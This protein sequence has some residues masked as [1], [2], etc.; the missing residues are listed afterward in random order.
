MKFT[1]HENFSFY[2]ERKT[3]PEKTP[4]DFW[5][6]VRTNIKLQHQALPIKPAPRNGKLPLS[7]AQ[8]RLWFLDQLQPDS[9]VHNKL[10]A[11]RFKGLLNLA[12]L[13]QSLNEIVQRHEILRTTFPAVKGQPIQVISSDITLKLTVIDLRELPSDQREAQ[14][15]RLALEEAEQPFNLERE[16]LWRVQLLHLTEGEHLFLQTVHHIIFDGWSYG[17]FMRE[18]AVLY[19]AFS[20]GKT[21]ML[22]ELPIQYADFA[23]YQRQ[24]LQGEVLVSQFDYWQQQLD[25][26]LLPLELPVDRPRPILP[27]YRGA[28][29]SL[30][31]SENLTNALKAL[32]HQEGVSLFVTLLAAFKT[33]LFRYTGQED[34]I[35]CSPVAGRNRVEIKKLIGYFNNLLVMRTDLG[36]NPSFRELMSRVSRTTLGAYQHQ[37][38]P[39]QKLTEL[40]NLVRTPLTRGMFVLQNT[41][42]QPLTLADISVTPLDLDWGTTN[43]DLSLSMKETEEQLIGVLSYKTDLFAG[44]T[45]TQMIEDFQ[46]LLVDLAANPD[47]CL[48][49][50]QRFD[51]NGNPAS[52]LPIQVSQSSPSPETSFVPPRTPT[53]E[54]LVT[55]WSDI[56]GVKVGICDSFFE[57]GGHSLLATQLISRI[58]DTFAVEWP[59]HCLFESPTIEALSKYLEA[60]RCQN[61]LQPPPPLQPVSRSQQ[62]LLSFAQQRLWFLDQLETQSTTYN[63]LTALRLIG[64]LQ[65]AVLERSIAEI[66]R[67]H[68]ALRTTFPMVN[69]TPVQVIA[70]ALTMT[71][72]VR[73]WQHLPEVK[74]SIEV[75]QLA[76]EESQQPFDLT[77]GSLMRVTLLRLGK[78]SHVLLLTVHHIVTDGWSMEIFVQELSTLYQAFSTE[79]RSP[80]PEL[81]IQY[82]DF[83]HWQRQWLQG[84]VL[85]SQLAY[86]KQ[87]LAGA[88][89][90]LQLP[91]DRPRPLVQTFRGRTEHFQLNSNLTK[92]LKLLSQR[93][94]ATLFMT[95]L[96]A[97]ATLLSYYSG[98]EDIIVGSGIANRNR[99]EIEPLIGFFVNILVL[100]INLQ[101]N[102]TF[103]ELLAQ[104]RQVALDAYAHQ[105]LPFEKLV[106]ELRPERKLNHSPLFQVAFFL[107]NMPRE[108][109]ELPDLS[110]IPWELEN[111]TAK[112][113][114]TLSMLELE[115][116]LRGSWEYNSDLFD[117]ATIAR[118]TEHFQ[119]LLAA[120]VVN[121]EQNLSALPLLTET[122]HNQLLVEW[123]DTQTEYPQDKCIHQLFEAQVERT[124]EAV[125]VVFEDQ[126]LKYGELNCRA[127]QLA[128]H[129]Q[130]WGVGP[131]VLVGICI[132]RSLE[133]I[134]GLL[135]ILKAGGAYLP[136]EPA[137]PKERLA[138][139]ISDAQVSLLLTTEALGAGLPE[140]EASVV[141]LDT[142][143]ELI[144][145][146]SERNLTS[147]VKSD[148]LAYVIYTSASTGR[149]KGVQIHHYSLVNFLNSMRLSPGLTAQDILLAITTISFDIAVLE[150]YLPLIVGAKVVLATRED[151]SEGSKLLSMLV[152]SGATVMQGTP[153]TWGLLLAAGWSGSDRL[154]VLCG[155][156][157]LT[158]ELANQ[159]LAKSTSVWNLYGP[160]ETSIWSTA[161]QVKSQDGSVCIG[162]PIANTQIYLLNSH[163]KPVPIGVPGELHIGGAG[164]AR[165]Y[166]NRPELTKE[167]FIPNPFSK[168]PSARLYKTGDLARYLPN[169]NIEFLDRLDHQVKIRGFR[170]ELG[171]V[172]S[173]LAQHPA[174]QQTVVIVREYL[175]DDKR[176]V[177]YV[178]PNETTLTHNQLRCFLK[179]KLPHHLVP[180]TFVLLNTLPLNPNGKV[181]RHTLPAPERIGQELAENFVA[182][183]DELEL[184]LAQIW[185]QVLGTYPVGVRNDFF[186][187][188]GHSLLAVN[189][190]VQ[191]EHKLGVDL[192][193][194]TLFQAPTIEQLA[195]LLRQ[196]GWSSSWSSL[197]GI[198]PSGLR[199]PFFFHGGAAD[200]IHW[201]KLG[202]YL[203]PDQPFYALQRPD[204]NRKQAPQLPV[205]EL[206]VQ[207]IQEIRTVQPKGPYL[208]GGQ[209]F[210]GTVVFE[211]AQ[212]FHRQGEKVDLLVL[213]DA[214]APQLVAPQLGSNPLSFI[215]QTLIHN[216]NFWLHYHLAQL[217]RHELKGKLTYFP[218]QLLKWLKFQLKQMIIDYQPFQDKL[219]RNNDTEDFLPH[220]L[221]YS[222]AEKRSR[223]AFRSY[224]PQAYP[225]RIILFRA[226]KQ[227]AEWYYGSQLGWEELAA[228]GVESHEIPGVFGT[229]LGNPSSAP[230]LTTKLRA[231]LDE[232]QAEESKN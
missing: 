57:L 184:Q 12:A 171:E 161:Y 53:E 168:E 107:Q 29:Q 230:L 51:Q 196:S 183:R 232:A 108:K 131:E 104:V 79:D 68:E 82:A 119:T 209:C 65:V 198:Q 114:L 156:E 36:G 210:G 179:E 135:A 176:L 212:Q 56:L 153:A 83:A 142:D 173:A 90:L 162:K 144:S 134:V 124:P 199:Q 5:Q 88:P 113:D 92:K 25:G 109:L 78:E 16:P 164:L 224:I 194:A 208:L 91:T 100:R 64:P 150:L 187:L 28:C 59:V 216:I 7:L 8:E 222:V 63:M 11:F 21:P 1:T 151:A 121:P 23:Q 219:S 40:P 31:L 195:R 32:S 18:L 87:Q 186:N 172:E 81:P 9:S 67:R 54:L 197:V 30:A 211:I 50:L 38:L 148:N 188:G 193:V 2:P 106:E 37:D 96:A 49:S 138:Y 132:D 177:A 98:Q 118:M 182:P 130:A 89:P 22:P 228:G 217:A 76:T 27:T 152:N 185:E 139:I 45:I 34:M 167:K 192:P 169:G 201:A 52:P 170:I 231:C 19:E 189:L 133:M 166:L 4:S 111:R 215:Y 206:A 70:P 74:Q 157:T 61:H 120:I 33:L 175:P 86:W 26:N 35:V 180:S 137:H 129:L 200:G 223:K 154:K 101:G 10:S 6:T 141:C 17:M 123:N 204:L 155:G 93:L 3:Q 218:G 140:H 229:L 75:Q 44:A 202:S 226:S 14:V 97:F 205:E 125:A 181:D 115:S 160:T 149:P 99:S 46:T 122:E 110:I 136:L 85:E 128:H 178:V 77:V 116:G 41:P 39:F 48:S 47:R 221:R 94:G 20:T 190:F 102:P 159:L 105:D 225:G 146:Q 43:F 117:A 58:R 66:V 13:E 214:F 207:C 55:I 165:G 227:P 72:S 203:S 15:H 127:N 103:P 73:D 42:S 84:E 145:Q 69:G 24:W 126:S 213:V 80:L 95:L 71:M 147:G 62:L 220:F 143:W 191:I 174:V 158:R 163:R 60:A 112:F